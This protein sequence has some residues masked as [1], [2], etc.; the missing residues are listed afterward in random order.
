MVRI[1]VGTIVRGHIT[2]SFVGSV[3]G[4]VQD[5]TTFSGQENTHNFLRFTEELK[6]LQEVSRV[7]TLP[8]LWKKLILS[9]FWQA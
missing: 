4:F 7:P 6:T 9:F 5:L 1:V 3:K 8:L 2:H